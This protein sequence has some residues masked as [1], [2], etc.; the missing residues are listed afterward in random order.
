VKLA[1]LLALIAAACGRSPGE[2]KPVEPAA[3]AGDATIAAADAAP[4]VSPIEGA[5]ELVTAVVDDWTATRAELRRYRR[6]GTAWKPVGEPWP[7]VIGSAGA[8][9]GIG[10]HG[11]GAPSGR[12]GPVKREGDDKSPAGAFTL[13][14]TYGYAR[15]APRGA[16]LPYT[17]VDDAWKC[18]DDPASRHYDR[19]VDRRTVTADWRSA[20][21]M[22]R[23]DDLYAQVID[24]DHNPGHTAGSGSCIFFHAWSGA[25]SATLGC[26]AMATTKLAE[27]ML[28]DPSAV[29]VLLPK[30]EYAVLASAWG[31]P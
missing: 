28:L 14:G 7:G 18:V 19:I 10:R 21:D 26:T 15:S 25:D 23:A 3:I 2:P 16:R 31:L 29:F 20:E 17:P 6:D 1:G 13:R 4:V 9:W 12:T 24:I 5:R 27:L 22:R 30:A 8:A 11:T